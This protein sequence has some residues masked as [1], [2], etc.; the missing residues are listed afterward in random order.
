MHLQ[1]QQ[2]FVVYHGF[3]CGLSAIETYIEMESVYDDGCFSYSALK[4]TSK[5][6]TS[7]K[8]AEVL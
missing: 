4:K 7:E 5:R 6:T 1:R 3:H 2:R 8:M